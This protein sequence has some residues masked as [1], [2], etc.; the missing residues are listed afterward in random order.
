MHNEI[1]LENPHLL[2]VLCRWVN[3]SA[4]LS[5]GLPS[6]CRK[7]KLYTVWEIARLSPHYEGLSHPELVV[8]VRGMVP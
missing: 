7:M 4:I 3:P 1:V 6:Q 8:F 5:V 2:L